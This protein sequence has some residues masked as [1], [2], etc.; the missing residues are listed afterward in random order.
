M[1]IQKNSMKDGSKD[2][3]VAIKEH[4]DQLY[5]IIEMKKKKTP[6]SMKTDEPHK[7]QKGVTE[8]DVERCEMKEE[9]SYYEL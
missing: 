9:E 6:D 7:V 4:E 1:A 3:P 5:D 2:V 8:S